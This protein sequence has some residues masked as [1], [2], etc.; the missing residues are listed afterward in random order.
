MFLTNLAASSQTVFSCDRFVSS[1]FLRHNSSSSATLVENPELSSFSSSFFKY[2]ALKPDER[3]VGAHTWR[4]PS[5]STDPS[6]QPIEATWTTSWKFSSVTAAA[7]T[8]QVFCNISKCKQ[9]LGS[10][11]GALSQDTFYRRARRSLASPWRRLQIMRT[12][13]DQR[14]R[15]ETYGETSLQ[16]SILS[17]GWGG[18]TT[19]TLNTIEKWKYFINARVKARKVY[20]CP[21]DNDHWYRCTFCRIHFSYSRIPEIFKVVLVIA[22]LCT[23]VHVAD[24]RPSSPTSIL[25]CLRDRRIFCLAKEDPIVYLEEDQRV[26]AGR[27][28]RT[29]FQAHL[30]LIHVDRSGAQGSTRRLLQ[31]TIEDLSILDVLV[32]VSHGRAEEVSRRGDYQI[33]AFIGDHHFAARTARTADFFATCEIT[34]TVYSTVSWRAARRGR[35][36]GVARPGRHDDQ[37]STHNSCRYRYIMHHCTCA[38]RRSH[39]SD[40]FLIVIWQIKKSAPFVWISLTHGG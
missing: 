12:I 11:H 16:V 27:Q 3:R 13:G 9:R 30:V 32:V 35:P 21:S 40:C 33:P 39:L 26:F 25:V 17:T 8:C 22:S 7:V 29:Q 1:R 14:R 31:E 28:L 24:T 18:T 6:P 36:R 15:R 2:D 34:N 19:T 37:R 20:R 4:R 38:W 5:I 10:L 23:C